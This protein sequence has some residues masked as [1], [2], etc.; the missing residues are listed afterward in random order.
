MYSREDLINAHYDGM[1][2]GLWR[3]AWWKDGVEYVGN[4]GVTLKEAYAKLEEDRNK[5]LN[6]GK[7]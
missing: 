7:V 3:H 4:S 6:E 5:E 2:E 1:R